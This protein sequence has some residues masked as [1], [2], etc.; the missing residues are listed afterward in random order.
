MLLIPIES[1]S[2]QALDDRVLKDGVLWS[3]ETRSPWDPE[4]VKEPG[5]W[6][7][8]SSR[9]REHEESGSRGVK[10]SGAREVRSSRNRELR[11]ARSQDPEYSPKKTYLGGRLQ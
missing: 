6:G 7:V 1:V 10:E 11:R 4:G 3:W 9:S 5:A 2:G 8:G